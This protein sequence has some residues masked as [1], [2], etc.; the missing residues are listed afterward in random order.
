[1][2]SRYLKL[3]QAI[4]SHRWIVASLF[5]LLALVLAFTGFTQL[6]LNEDI[7]EFI[8]EEDPQ[9]ITNYRLLSAAPYSKKVMVLLEV[10]QE[11]QVDLNALCVQLNQGLKDPYFISPFV[12]VTPEEAQSVF[13]RITGHLPVLLSEPEQK[14]LLAT[15]DSPEAIQQLLHKNQSELMLP[16]GLFMKEV[17]LNDP[18]RLRDHTAAILQS[19]SFSDQTPGSSGAL[20]TADGKRA[21]LVMDTRIPPTDINQIALM[22]AHFN[23]VWEQIRMPGVEAD[24]LGTHR[25]S[26]AN[27]TSIKADANS[28]LLLSIILIATIFL[29]FLK[30]WR[31]LLLFIGP[32]FVFAIAFGT[33]A[34]S[35]SSVSTISIGFAAILLG[36]TI[37]YSLHVYLHARESALSKYEAIWRM[38]GPL[39]LS[40]LTTVLA[41][42]V[43]LLSSVK[44][45]R[46]F[47]VFS[48]AGLLASFVFSVFLLPAFVNHNPGKAPALRISQQPTTHTH[49]NNLLIIG[50]WALALVVMMAG[51]PGIRLSLDNSDLYIVPDSLRA[52]ESSID[53]HWGHGVR[54]SGL[55]L[56]EA[57]NMDDAL[58]A[59]DRLHGILKSYDPSGHMLSLHRILPSI[60]TQKRHFNHWQSSLDTTKMDWLE[61]QLSAASWPLSGIHTLRTMSGAFQPILAKDYANTFIQPL[62]DNLLVQEPGV[63]RVF[64]LAAPG[65]LEN[66]SEESM[67]AGITELSAS[68]ISA[69]INAITVKQFRNLVL[70]TLVA[71]L[72]FAGLLLRD[73]RISI[74]AM[75]PMLSG[76][77]CAMG[78]VGWAQTPLTFFHAAAALLL[79]GLGVDYGIMI[80]K[81]AQTES[82]N[83]TARSILVSALTTIGAFGVLTLG[84]HPF[85]KV[86]GTN[87]TIGMIAATI[88]ALVIAPRLLQLLKPHQP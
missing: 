55:Y 73:W 17:I 88:T 21:L 49:K 82:R 87:V 33:L 67:H 14:S 40:L 81:L 9:L 68:A 27:A 7:A 80:A 46:E 10:G 23:T 66:R 44:T 62:I 57:E 75:L 15:L 16:D 65:A 61:S 83:T 43:L 86:L 25:Y 45:H 72:I 56:V 85:L 12:E 76:L 71:V 11:T 79:I 41:F 50:A 69:R 19:L 52:L 24:W 39:A 77:V 32:A 42:A 4:E 54:K 84:E 6:R 34:L 74:T 8:P 60:A 36:I 31:A 38:T 28:I 22:I 64:T 59:N 47:A 78:Y 37:D 3:A 29:V 5:V 53:E 1:M 70:T 2:K 20:I 63:T 58:A 13:T 48:I 51:I 18:F 35:F 26:Y 30:E